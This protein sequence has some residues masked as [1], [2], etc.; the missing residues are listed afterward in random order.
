ISLQEKAPATQVVWL[1]RKTDLQRAYGGGER[2][3]L[4]ERG[5]LGARLA[6]AVAAGRVETVHPFALAAIESHDGALCLSNG[7]TSVD[8]EELIIAAGFRPDLDILREVRLDL[9][10]ALECPRI[11]APLIDPNVHSCGT[12]RPHGAR[13][14]AQPDSGFYI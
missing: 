5:A 7:A 1:S 9:D 11:L 10:P 4:A 6:R 12:V 13:E 2:D 3:G 8:C 14:L